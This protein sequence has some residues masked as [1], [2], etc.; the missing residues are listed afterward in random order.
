MVRMA[1]SGRSETDVLL[2]VY[3]E[4]QE[5]FNTDDYSTFV[6]TMKDQHQEDLFGH[7]GQ[8]RAEDSALLQVRIPHHQKEEE[9]ELP[10]QGQPGTEDDSGVGLSPRP[11]AGSG[12]ALLHRPQ[13]QEQPGRPLRDH[14]RSQRKHASHRGNEES[15]SEQASGVFH[16]H[17]RSREHGKRSLSI[18]Q[19]A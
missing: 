4:V 18:R 19:D 14:M 11:R 1:L 2:Q 6:S 13:N 12:Q 7:D 9:L 16:C 15:F 17:K 8:E 5:V 10:T 3:L